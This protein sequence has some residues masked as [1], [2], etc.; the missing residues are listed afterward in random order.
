MEGRT[1]FFWFGFSQGVNIVKKGRLVL[2][3]C[4]S[5]ISF[6]KGRNRQGTRVLHTCPQTNF[7]FCKRDF[8]IVFVAL[9]TSTWKSDKARKEGN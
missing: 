3:R 4:C 9:S 2:F 1:G 7:A 5:R 8:N 6:K